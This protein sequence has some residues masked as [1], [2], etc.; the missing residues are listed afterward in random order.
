MVALTQTVVVVTAALTRTQTVEMGAPTQTVEMAV[1]TRTH[2]LILTVFTSIRF[3]SS[4]TSA[5][6]GDWTR[7]CVTVTTFA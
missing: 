4:P 7:A 2:L 1:L 3:T 6:A 5:R